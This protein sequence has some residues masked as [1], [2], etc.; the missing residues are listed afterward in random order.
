MRGALAGLVFALTVLGATLWFQRIHRPFPPPQ[1]ILPPPTD[2]EL[3]LR[4]A[5]IIC[6]GDDVASCFPVAAVGRE[7]CVAFLTAKH[8]VEPEPE[9]VRL[10]SGDQMPVVACDSH[11]TLD[12]GLIWARANPHLPLAPLKLA[13]QNPLIGTEALLAGYPQE[14]GLWLSRGLIG[15]PDSRGW[16][17]ASI[18]IYF[19]CSGGPVLVDGRV[20]GI[21]KGIEIDQYRRQCVS[22]LSCIILVDSFRDWV[23]EKIAQGPNVK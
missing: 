14:C 8:C 23:R 10:L 17:W 9:G 5:A 3:A 18:P 21:G 19:G 16:H 13:D 15:S 2:V 1:I 4:T 22:T 12:V 6:M 20:V 11:P 7:G